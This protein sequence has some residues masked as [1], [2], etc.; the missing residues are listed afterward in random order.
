VLQEFFVN[1]TRKIARPLSAETAKEIVRVIQDLQGT[2]DGAGPG[3]RCMDV[4]LV[5]L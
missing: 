2:H 3:K 1:V 4:P 5:S